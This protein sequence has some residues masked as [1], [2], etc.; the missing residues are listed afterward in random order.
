MLEISVPKYSGNVDVTECD[1][2]TLIL[3]PCNQV[4]MVT[5]IYADDRGVFVINL[6]TGTA[7]PVKYMDS[8]DVR[9]YN[10]NIV[11]AKLEV[12]H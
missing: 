6:R 5:R 7:V 12:T 10:G 1:N 2:G 9:I 4:L 3:T 8:P 11:N